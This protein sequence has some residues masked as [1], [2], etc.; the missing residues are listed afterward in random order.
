MERFVILLIF[1]LLFCLLKSQKID[2]W[3]G[4]KLGTT[5]YNMEMNVIR[6]GKKDHQRAVSLTNEKKELLCVTFQRPNATVTNILYDNIR[7]M[8]TSCDWAIVFYSGTTEQ[9]QSICNDPKISSRIIHCKANE[10]SLVDRYIPSHDGSKQIK[11]SIP[12]TVL[13]QDIVSYLGGYNRVFLMDED[14]SLEGF[15]INLF[16]LHW[17]C[18]FHPP[19]LIAQPVVYESNQYINYLNKKSWSRGDRKNVIASGVGLVEQQVPFFDAIFLEWF[20][21]RVLSLTKETALAYGVDWGHDRS[22][23]NA[24]R[25]Y[26]TYVLN[27]P[28][29]SI[30]CAVLPKTYIHHLN[31]KSMDSKRENRKLFQ[32]N[33]QKVVQH[34][35]NLFPTW[36]EMD[37]L[38]PNN[39]LDIKRNGLKFPRI[40]ELNPK[41][42]AVKGKPL[43]LNN[44]YNTTTSSI[45]M[46]FNKV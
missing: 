3:T 9:I 5:E 19:P 36:V 15:D 31:L 17:N 45:N 20:I 40:L 18:A 1:S 43:S 25:L 42:V 2:V 14:I 8:G 41:C 16:L 26:N 39:P 30:P 12:K 11:I 7:I 13:Y 46:K 44:L 22:W 28:N 33:G 34:Y 32:I 27:Y 29:T 37:V 24:A 38:K 10:A 6:Q 35:V 21:K 4:S 23:C